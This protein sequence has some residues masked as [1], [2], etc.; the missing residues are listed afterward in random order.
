VAP[1]TEW[2]L[3]DTIAEGAFL[4]TRQLDIKCVRGDMK[5]LNPKL[6]ADATYKYDLCDEEGIF[7][8]AALDALVALRDSDPTSWKAI[9]RIE[10]A[11]RPCN[12][13]AISRLGGGGRCNEG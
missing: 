7:Y 10:S 4:D 1:P 3:Q 12:K 5:Q 6:E 2:A 13:P 8:V 11:V 9:Q